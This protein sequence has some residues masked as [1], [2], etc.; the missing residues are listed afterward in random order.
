MSLISPISH[1][2]PSSYHNIILHFYPPSLT[3]VN[4]FCNTIS[5]SSSHFVLNCLIAKHWF[6]LPMFFLISLPPS[7]EMSALTYMLKPKFWNLPFLNTVC[8]IHPGILPGNPQDISIFWLLLSALL[9]HPTHAGPKPLWSEFSNWSALSILAL[10]ESIQ[11]T[12]LFQ[13]IN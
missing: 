6:Q 13:G 8:I 12:E 1:F 4:S 11:R 9:R 5:E 7:Q 10:L 3:Q 2:G